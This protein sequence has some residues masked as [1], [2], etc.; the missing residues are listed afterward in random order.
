MLFHDQPHSLSVTHSLTLT[1]ALLWAGG[2]SR[3]PPKAL[4]T[5]SS[6]DSNTCG[7]KDQ[8]INPLLA[9]QTNSLPHDILTLRLKACKFSYS[10]IYQHKTSPKVISRVS[11]AYL[12]LVSSS[13]NGHTTTH[14]SHLLSAKLISPRTSTAS[15]SPTHT[16]QYLY[17]KILLTECNLHFLSGRKHKKNLFHCSQNLKQ[18]FLY[19]IKRTKFQVTKHFTK[20]NASCLLSLE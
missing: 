20:C 9:S 15:E 16:S 19:W 1:S 4:P 7:S 12:F 6:S 13:L 3:Q 8:F 2:W 17:H 5:K 11:R 14:R 18:V 10:A